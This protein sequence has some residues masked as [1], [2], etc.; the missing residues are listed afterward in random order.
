YR[1]TRDRNP[2]KVQVA[3]QVF[4]GLLIGLPLL[5]IILVL[6]M[7]A[8]DVFLDAMSRLPRFMYEVDLATWMFRFSFVVFARMLFFGVLQLLAAERG[9]HEKMLVH[10]VKRAPYRFQAIMV[11]TVLGLMLAVYTLFFGVKFTYLF[12][13]SLM[14]G[15]T[16]AQYARRGFYELLAV[17]LINWSVLLVTLGRTR[18]GGPLLK[19]ACSLIIVVSGVLL[20]SSFG[21]LSLYESA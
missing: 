20:V 2:A 6:L 18:A 4:I 14:S 19:V 11:L 9:R 8:D 15:F 5:L 21:R 1:M 10:T 17:V 16:Y 3:K 7:A 12:N 13:D